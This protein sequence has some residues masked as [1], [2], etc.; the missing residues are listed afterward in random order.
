[1]ANNLR[2]AAGTVTYGD[3]S[4]F[5]YKSVDQLITEDF[6]RI[7]VLFNGV[8]ANVMHEAK[9]RYAGYQVFF[10]VSEKNEGSAGGYLTLLRHVLEND[11]CE[12]LNEQGFD[13]NLIHHLDMYWDLFTFLKYYSVEVWSA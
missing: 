9:V 13:F 2:V 1:M 4:G 7:Y 6:D 11:D 12:F 5:L 3:R 10:I 8:C